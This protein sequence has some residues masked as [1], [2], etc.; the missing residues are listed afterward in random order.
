MHRI[1]PLEFIFSCNPFQGFA[2][3][4]VLGN[5]ATVDPM[6]YGIDVMAC[7]PCT[8]SHNRGQ[9]MME[10]RITPE[11]KAVEMKQ[12]CVVV[13]KPSVFVDRRPKC[14]EM[15]WSGWE[16]GLRS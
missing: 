14:G 13:V 1:V 11:L 15:V 10:T 2:S 12:G 8:N 6:F 9:A 3:G 16:A 7:L 4:D 5:V